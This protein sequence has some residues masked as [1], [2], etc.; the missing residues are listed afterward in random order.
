MSINQNHHSSIDI[1]NFIE[2]SK[3]IYRTQFI[4]V[5]K[6]KNEDLFSSHGLV[7]KGLSNSWIH[8]T[9]KSQ[10]TVY[11]QIIPLAANDRNQRIHFGT[12]M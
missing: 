10:E 9:T 12:R 11:L 8:I 4:H 6:E 7:K 1:N 5:E 3:G 2:G